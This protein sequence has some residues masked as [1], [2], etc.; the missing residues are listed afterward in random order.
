MDPVQK[1][2]LPTSLGVNYLVHHLLGLPI[3]DSQPAS[4]VIRA[5]RTGDQL[6][7]GA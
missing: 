3:S 5:I 1:A 7:E 6:P 4:L 2:L